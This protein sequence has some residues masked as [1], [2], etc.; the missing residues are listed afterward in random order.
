MSKLVQRVYV[1]DLLF[2][3]Q[4]VMLVKG[5]H[6]EGYSYNYE[7]K[8]PLWLIGGTFFIFKTALSASNS[9]DLSSIM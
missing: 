6:I 3:D 2:F 7:K 8:K 5:L 9:I 4:Y 1:I